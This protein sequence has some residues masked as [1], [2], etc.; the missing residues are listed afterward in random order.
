[1][2]NKPRFTTP[3]YVDRYLRDNYLLLMAVLDNLDVFEDILRY[4]EVF[5]D[6]NSWEIKK[7]KF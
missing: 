4:L 2:D 5:K 3:F 6:I 7:Y 1:M